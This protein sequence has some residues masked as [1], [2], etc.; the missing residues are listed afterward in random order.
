MADRRDP[1]PA[2]PVL[3]ANPPPSQSAF[4]TSTSFV[5][6][7]EFTATLNAFKKEIV[8]EFKEMRREFREELASERRFYVSLGSQKSGGAQQQQVSGHSGAERQ[9][10]RTHDG[11]PICNFCRK[12]GHIERFCTVKMKALPSA[13]H[14]QTENSASGSSEQ[15][16]NP[17]KK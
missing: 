9:N 1:P 2:L 14:V 11:R 5:S 10:K 16:N 8:T 6:R 7:E 17:S 13:N 15:T 12:P 4:P 3:L